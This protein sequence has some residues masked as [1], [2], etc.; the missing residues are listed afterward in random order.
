M[1]GCLKTKTKPRRLPPIQVVKAPISEP[2][3]MSWDA[4]FT[5]CPGTVL[6][7]MDVVGDHCVLVAATMSN[8]LELI[9]VPLSRPRA[10]YTLQVN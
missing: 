5:P 1:D 4:I 9:V 8:E 3:M 7:D 2:S 6:K 10:A